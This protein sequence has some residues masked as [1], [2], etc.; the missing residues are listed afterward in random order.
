MGRF[1]GQ[2]ESGRTDMTKISVDSLLALLRSLGPGV[3]EVSCHPGHLE[4]RPD[5][6]YNREREVELRSLCDTQVRAAIREE[7]IRLISFREYA[8]IAGRS[9]QGA[10]AAG[11][12]PAASGR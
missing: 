2:P 6:L 4:S 11:C 7:G 10:V 8:R 1:W 3:S 5:A 12:P 9:G